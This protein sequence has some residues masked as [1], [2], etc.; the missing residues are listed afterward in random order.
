M[1]AAEFRSPKSASRLA[2]LSA[3]FSLALS[4]I[5]LTAKFWVY[6]QTSSQAVL[7]DA[8]ES[9][10]NVLTA[11]LA[12][13]VVF[14]SDKPADREHPY[15]HGKLEYFSAAIEGGLIAFAAIWIVFQAVYTFWQGHQARALTLGALVLLATAILNLA[16][17]LAILRVG[18]RH[19]SLALVA[20]GHHLISDFWTSTA[21]VLGLGIAEG[22]KILWLD[23][24]LAA[25]VGVHLALTGYRLVRFSAGGLLDEEDPEV[26]RKLHAAI[27]ENIPP[28]IIQIHHTRVIRAGRYHHIDTH[29]V[30]PEFWTVAQAHAELS[31]FERRV[32]GA[33][34]QDGELH[35]HMDPCRRAY[36]RACEYEPCPVRAQKFEG[37]T[38]FTIDE[39]TDPDEP[40][41]FR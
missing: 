27:R 21:V 5:L 19:H 8:W 16:A 32:I 20:S 25:L 23:S 33:Y 29:A 22:F 11:V 37:R 31:N 24:V 39:L 13:V 10:I 3:V 7:S 36:C 12:L 9:T 35:V 4:L 38:E 18:R 34:P 41:H 1:S 40:P 2:I 15:G 14:Y 30:V 26:L 28:G 6:R 17:G